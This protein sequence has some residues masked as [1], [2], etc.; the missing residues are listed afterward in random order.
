MSVLVIPKN[1]AQTLRELTGEPR[2]DVAL[3][4]VLQDARSYRLQQIETAIR[5]FEAK[6]KMT[7]DEYHKLWESEDREAFYG[8]EVEQDFL[9]WEAL[10]TQKRRLE[11][12]SS[13]P[14]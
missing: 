9:N 12:M 8:W 3:M 5:A 4:M 1:T 10:E 11:A 14:I 6:Y 2:P 7:F 13:W